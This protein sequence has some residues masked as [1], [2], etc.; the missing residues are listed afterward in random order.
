MYIRG[1]LLLLSAS[2]FGP[3]SL[4]TTRLCGKRP[5]RAPTANQPTIESI[6][7]FLTSAPT[8]L[9]PPI[10]QIFVIRLRRPSLNSEPTG[11]TCLVLVPLAMKEAETTGELLDTYTRPSPMT[12]TNY[13]APSTIAP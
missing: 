4:C 11:V 10:K 5:S 7:E 9:P 12:L 8:G 13:L 3:W 2:T 1:D 6:S